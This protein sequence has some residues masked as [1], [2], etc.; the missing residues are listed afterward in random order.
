M[1]YIQTFESFNS[2]QLDEG[3]FSFLKGLFKNP[4]QKRKLD[5]LSA[6]LTATRVDIGK[7]KLEGDPIEDF[8]NELEDKSDSYTSS[9][10]HR[11]NDDNP[12]ED[13]I[14]LLEDLEEELIGMMDE[15]GQENDTLKA[16]VSKVKLESR[17]Q[18]TEKLMRIADGAIAKVLAKMKKKDM[19]NIKHADKELYAMREKY[20]NNVNL[21][22]RL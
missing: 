15:I 9:R 2:S 20:M 22:T 5:Q 10:S 13:K 21:D 11:S 1:K 3:L 7:L 16:Y 8:E 12:H 4:A 19:Q 14:K 18:S 17:L 6:K